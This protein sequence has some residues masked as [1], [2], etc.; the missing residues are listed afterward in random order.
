VHHD[1]GGYLTTP[2]FFLKTPNCSKNTPMSGWTTPKNVLESGS[3]RAYLGGCHVVVIDNLGV[4]PLNL[5]VVKNLMGVG[6]TT[7]AFVP[8]N[9]AKDEV[10]SSSGWSFGM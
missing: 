4:A 1:C 9:N 7:P 10:T 6:L 2:K 8:S 5:G 3:C